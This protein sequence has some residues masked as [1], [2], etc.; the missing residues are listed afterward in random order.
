LN[1][2]EIRAPFAGVI[3]RRF[4]QAGDFVTPTTSAS[5]SDGATSTSIVELAKGLEVEAKVPEAIIARIQLGQLVDIRSDTYPNATFKGD[6]R[7]LAPRAVQDQQSSTSGTGSGVTT[8]HVKVSLKIGQE[9]LKSGMNVKLRF[10]GNKIPQASVI[11]LAA[12]VTQATGQ[13]GVWVQDAKKQPQFRP[14]SL[15]SVSEDQVQI[16]KGICRGQRI[17]LSPPADQV[18]PGVDTMGF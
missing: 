6:V 18:I 8:F 11:P 10:L 1:N 7:L 4:A 15:G 5:T 14:V 2:T 9:Q 17:L 12:V 3:T 13:T 16:L